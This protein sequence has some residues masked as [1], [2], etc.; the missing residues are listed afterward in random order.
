MKVFEPDLL[1]GAPDVFQSKGF[2]ARELSDPHLL[3]IQV[4]PDDCTG[5]NVC[6]EQCPATSKQVAGHKAINMEPYAEHADREREN[7]GFFEEIPYLDRTLLPTTPSRARRSCSRCS[8]TRAPAPAAARRPTSSSS[9]SCSATG[10]WSPTPPA[11]RRSTAATCRRHPW[12]QNDAGRGPAWANSLFEDNAEFG[13]GIRLA[14]E[15][16]TAI[17]RGLLPASAGRSVTTWSATCST[18]TSRPSRASRSSAPASPSCSAASRR[19]TD[20]VAAAHLRTL[21]GAL[22]RKDVWIVGGDGWAYDIGYGGLD[23]VLASGENVNVIVLDTEVYSNT[24]GQ[25]SKA[26]PRAAVAKFATSGRSV[27]KKDLGALAMQYGTVFV[28]QIALGANEVQTVRAL[29]EAA[30]WEGRRW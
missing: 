24:G 5:C 6:V 25:A 20:D 30:A 2:K 17:A 26:T 19:R 10:S 8:P 27:P 29:Q 23:H 1:D 28:A 14:V 12:G 22:V 13:L 7:F 18:P 11:A 4:S 9:P 21:A 15:Q 16:Q 3:T